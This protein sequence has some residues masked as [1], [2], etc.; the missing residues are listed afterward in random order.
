MPQDVKLK[1]KVDPNV[2]A[3]ILLGEAAGEGITGLQFVRD[4][5]FNRAMAQG[6]TLKQ[7][8]T[9]PHQFSAY[10][11]PDLAQFYQK[12]PAT[13]RSL[14]EQLVKEAQSP[15]Y[16]PAYPEQNYVTADLWNKRN[17]LSPNHWI[18]QMQISRTVGN[19]VALMPRKRKS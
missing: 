7:V 17:T 10:A 6:K 14:A 12:Q 4:I 16:Q 2:V 9:A 3:Q 8:A 5:M 15:D 11:R 1:P 13:L 19:H 18:N